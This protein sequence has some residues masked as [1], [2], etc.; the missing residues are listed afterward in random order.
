MRM[1]EVIL[2][3]VSGQIH[4]FQAAEILG[5]S[6]RTIQRWKRY[7][8]WRGYDGLFD[9]RRRTPSPKRVP[10][11]QVEA[12]L[13]LYRQRYGDFNVKH[14][15]EKLIEEHHIR[16]SYTWV[17]MALQTAG[18][19]QRRARRGPHR[20]RRP[21][22][23]LSGMLVHL[24]ASRHGWLLRCPEQM[25][26][27]LVLLDDATS[28]VYGAALVREED[29]LSVLQL[30]YECVRRHGVFCALYTDRASHFAFTPAKGEPPDK[31]RPTQVG[32][33]LK[34]LHIQHILAHSPQARGRSERLFGTW[35]GRLPQELR[36]RGI[37]D[38]QTAN[39]YI[40]EHFIPDYNRRF[41]VAAE[42]PGTAFVRAPGAA[43]LQRI[44]C[45][46]HTR[47]VANDNTITYGRR[48]LQLERHPWRL[49]FARSSVTVREHL[50]GQISLWYGPRLIGRYG[51]QGQSLK[52]ASRPTREEVA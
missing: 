13:K 25:D 39:A 11:A 2:R 23:P 6:V 9:R 3:A 21:R 29:T 32:R 46:E 35:Q 48:I 41:M 51:A 4:W 26:D 42:Q 27:L 40:Q 22:R 47:V 43:S 38:R 18:L 33:V 17:K 28:Q 37:R 52:A 24:D 7:Y 31:N 15:H 16:L 34:Q 19:V 44:F 30:L 45:L 50:D 8:E 36:L 14:F 10:L 1:Q 5:V 49:S 20:I 12:V